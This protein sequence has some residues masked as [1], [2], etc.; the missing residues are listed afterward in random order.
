VLPSIWVAVAILVPIMSLLRFC[1]SWLRAP[2]VAFILGKT[3]PLLCGPACR[4]CGRNRV[5]VADEAKANYEVSGSE[6]EEEHENEIVEAM[7]AKL[8]NRFTPL[9]LEVNQINGLQE[10][11][12][13]IKVV[14]V[15]AVFKK[16]AA[17]A[18]RA[19]LVAAALANELAGDSARLEVSENWTPA[20]WREILKQREADAQR[21]AKQKA[22]GRMRLTALLGKAPVQLSP[23]SLCPASHPYVLSAAISCLSI[24]IIEAHSRDFEDTTTA[25]WVGASM[26]AALIK[27]VAVDSFMLLLPD[28][29]DAE[30]RG[31]VNMWLLRVVLPW[32]RRKLKAW[33]G[34]ISVDRVGNDE[35]NLPASD[36]SEDEVSTVDRLLGIFVAR[37]GAP[38][39]GF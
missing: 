7:I 14:L 23:R 30:I 25:Y 36:S 37:K 22:R 32:L 21:R 26:L 33:R 2:I 12:A 18:Q 8:Q 5:D 13:K 4:R 28:F 29:G 16:V 38:C 39:A 9:H 6:E 20:Q 19:S 1:F 31:P 15:S 34:E 11:P 10:S 3:T 35:G 27:L 24:L 17:E